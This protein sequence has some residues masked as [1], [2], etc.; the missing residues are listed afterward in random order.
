MCESEIFT[1]NFEVA[2][3]VQVDLDVCVEMIK[4][5]QEL[6]KKRII[7]SFDDNGSRLEVLN[8]RYGPYIKYGKKN[9]KIPKATDPKE[10][11]KDDCLNLIQK[12]L[13]K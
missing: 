12:S 6:E 9:Y 11:T 3:C 4:N 5:H 7:N 10:L 8:G 13:K 1:K 2:F